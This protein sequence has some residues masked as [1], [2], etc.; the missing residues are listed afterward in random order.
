MS[1]RAVERG[2]WGNEVPADYRQI[3]KHLQKLPTATV[4]LIL[5]KPAIETMMVYETTPDVTF[6]QRAYL[7]YEE[8]L[9][10]YTSK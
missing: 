8:L 9:H 7:V 10:K 6:L 2:L 1:G 5:R 3:Q 4:T